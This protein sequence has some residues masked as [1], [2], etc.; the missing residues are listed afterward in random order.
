MSQR[1][2]DE[3]IVVVKRRAEVDPSDWDGGEN[4][5]QVAEMLKAKG[6]T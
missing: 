6:G 5:A 1:D 3:T 4:A 2:A